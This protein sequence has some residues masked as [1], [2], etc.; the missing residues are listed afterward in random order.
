MSNEIKLYDIR[1]HDYPNKRGDNFRSL[2]VFE[3][4]VCGALTNQIIMGGSAGYGKC[5]ICPNSAN[6]WHNE[7]EEQIYLLAK[8]LKQSCRQEAESYRE[9]IKEI[10]NRYKEEI[11]NELI[12]T[13]DLNLKRWVTNFYAASCLCHINPLFY[14]YKDYHEVLDVLPEI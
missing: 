7:L 10:K 6:C 14:K 3:C 8:A 12:G 1:K 4:W 11:K 13:P 9:K 5:A 2:Q